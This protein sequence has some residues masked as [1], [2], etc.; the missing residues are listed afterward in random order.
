MGAFGDA[1]VPAATFDP[2]A[3][4]AVGQGVAPEVMLRAQLNRFADPNAG[5]LFLFPTPTATTGAPDSDVASRVEAVLTS[6]AS[7]PLYATATATSQAAIGKLVG[8]VQVDVIG[9][10]PTPPGT[11][12]AANIAQLTSIVSGYA[13]V[14]NLPAPSILGTL[15]GLDQTTV[16]LIG[17]AALAAYIYFTKS[18]SK[19]S[20]SK[21]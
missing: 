19:P 14:N 10:P 6:Y 21:R 7:S 16:I 17:A 8:T 13:D 3:I 15:A 5:A 20:R 1:S 11:F 18:K 12:T 2:S 9:P 4:T